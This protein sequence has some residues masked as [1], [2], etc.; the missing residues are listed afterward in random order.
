MRVGRRESSGGIS[1]DGE[2]IGTRAH[3][4]AVDVV[5]VLVTGN[6]QVRSVSRIEEPDDVISIGCGICG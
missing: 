1:V 3:D 2:V 5:C 6:G 4:R